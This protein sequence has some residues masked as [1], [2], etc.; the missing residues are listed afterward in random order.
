MINLDKTCFSKTLWQNS[1]IYSISPFESH[2][3]QRMSFSVQ[4]PSENWLSRSIAIFVLNN[5]NNNITNNGI[6]GQNLTL[7]SQNY[8][9]TLL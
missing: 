4:M 2:L 6:L 1:L 5:N 8:S 7:H 9:Q 3:L